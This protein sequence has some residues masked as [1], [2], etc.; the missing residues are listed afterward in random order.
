MPNPLIRNHLEIPPLLPYSNVWLFIFLAFFRIW[1]I[2]IKQK[3][4]LQVG[5]RDP[6]VSCR[7]VSGLLELAVFIF[8]VLPDLWADGLFPEGYLDL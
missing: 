2:I 8:K 5:G 1:E 4:I 3:Y 6:G 7:Q